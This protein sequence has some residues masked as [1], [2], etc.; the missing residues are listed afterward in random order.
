MSI[1]NVPSFQILLP[2]LRLAIFSQIGQSNRRVQQCSRKENGHLV[3]QPWGNIFLF[4]NFQP[5]PCSLID[6]SDFKATTVKE[7]RLLCWRIKPWDEP[8]SSRLFS[9][10]MAS[11]WG[12]DCDEV[13]PN[14]FIGDEASARNL[15]FLRRMGIDHVLN[16]AEGVWTDCSFVD[17]NE[18]YYA[19]TGIAYLGMQLWD[20]TR[21]C[22]VPYL[23]CANEFIAKAMAGGGKCLVHCQMGVSR[24][25][26]MAMA[27]L[28]MSLKWDAA[29][30]MRELRKRRDV[31][32]NDH[33]LAA[34]VELDNQLRR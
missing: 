20:S 16:A 23:G 15:A 26:T 18:D 21:V 30:A 32:P 31:R 7:L 19:N 4:L 9:S 5:E 24:S 13:Y 17:L 28:M 2:S 1:I 12:V 22:I 6:E 11:G 27:Y 29:D 14:L 3:D 10:V 34:I 25:C 8:K 33:F